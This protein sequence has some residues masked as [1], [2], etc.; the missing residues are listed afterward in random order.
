MA[1]GPKR[2]R[3]PADLNRRAFEIV[4]IATGEETDS[5]QDSA[6]DSARK[7]GAVSEEG[8]LGSPRGERRSP[9]SEPV[10]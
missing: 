7:E 3:R 5:P 10:L 1:K 9:E 4:R 6:A 8:C 2:E